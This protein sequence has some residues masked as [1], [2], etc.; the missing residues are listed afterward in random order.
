LAEAGLSD[1]RETAPSYW[2]VLRRASSRSDSEDEPGDLVHNGRN[3][4][5]GNFSDGFSQTP[6]S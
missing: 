4:L 2:D 5:K 3:R 1:R 6:T